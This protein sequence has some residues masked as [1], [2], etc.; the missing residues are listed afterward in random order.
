MTLP[1]GFG[2]D[3]LPVAVQLVGR[4]L[5]EDTLLALAMQ[6]EA[7]LPANNRRPA[8]AGMRAL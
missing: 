3:G 4:P 5:A 6:L 1:V 2:E 8:V 7:A